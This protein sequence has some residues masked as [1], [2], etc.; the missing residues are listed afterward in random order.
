MGENNRQWKNWWILKII[1]YQDTTNLYQ[2]LWQKIIKLQKHYLGSVK[3]D[4]LD[5][6]IF[7]VAKYNNGI[8]S[9]LK[10]AIDY[11]YQEWID[12]A[13]GI[14]SY[15]STLGVSAANEVRL[16]LFRSKSCDSWDTCRIKLVHRFWEHESIPTCRFPSKYRSTVIRWSYYLVY[17]S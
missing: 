3:T 1:I 12:K 6:F 17:S 10:D 11:L 8:T 7:V 13:T 9:G 5:G 14:V 4:S 15:G 2:Q 16:I